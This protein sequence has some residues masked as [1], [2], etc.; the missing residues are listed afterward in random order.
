MK[1]NPRCHRA[2]WEVSDIIALLYRAAFGQGKV[3]MRFFNRLRISSYSLYTGFPQKLWKTSS[4]NAL[5]YTGVLALCLTLLPSCTFFKGSK[6]DDKAATE[7]KSAGQE[8]KPGESAKAKEAPKEKKLKVS[9]DSTLIDK[10]EDEVKKKFGEPDVVSKTPENQI[11]WTYKPKWKIWPDNSD[12]VY[13]EFMDGKV[14][15]IV[16]AVR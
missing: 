5:L 16:R 10:G 13:V 1:N 7:V 11:I 3:I 14:T 6:K 2:L 9:L 12:T 4:R 8:A 15:K